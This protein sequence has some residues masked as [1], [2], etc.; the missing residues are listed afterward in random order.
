MYINEHDARYGMLILEGMKNDEERLLA[1]QRP[2]KGASSMD[3]SK[4]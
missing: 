2:K 4:L 1:N 3:F